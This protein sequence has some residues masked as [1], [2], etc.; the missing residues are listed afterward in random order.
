MARE[1]AV[2]GNVVTRLWPDG[3]PVEVWGEAG[4]LTDFTWQ[5]EAHRVL[6]VCNRWWIHTCWWEPGEAVWR[7]YLKVATDTG[8]LCLLYRNLLS[9]DW[10]LARLYD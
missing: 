7:E 6:Q 10:F 8:L 1:L 2:G 4:M 5:G 3:E 9:G